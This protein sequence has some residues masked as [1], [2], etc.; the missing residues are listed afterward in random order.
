M[1]GEE[2]ET[3]QRLDDR[4]KKEKKGKGRDGQKKREELRAMSGFL[5]SVS[6]PS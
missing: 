2:E 5:V 6:S 1:A 3:G 4:R